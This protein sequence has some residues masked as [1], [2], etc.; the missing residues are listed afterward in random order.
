[1][2]RRTLR[3]LRK[4]NIEPLAFCDNNPLLWGEKVEGVRVFSLPEAAAKYGRD[5]VF[6]ITIWGGRATDTM[7]DRER[8]LRGV[9]CER[10]THFGLLYWKH[11]DAFFP[12][13]AANAAHHLLEQRDDVST[14]A[15][16]WSDDFSRREY[17]AQLRW[18]LHF[19]FDGLAAPVPG[20][21]Y[22]RDEFRP[23]SDRERFVDCGAFDGDTVESFIHHSNG[24]F[25]QVFAFEP[26]PLNFAKLA[27]SVSQTDYR[28]RIKIES[29][30]VG[31]TVCEVPFTGGGSEASA[32]GTGDLH[33]RCIAL[34]EYLAEEEPTFIKMDIEGFELEALAGARK[35]I[36]EQTPT[37]A[38]CSYHAQ[39]HLW[40]IPLQIR[41]YNPSYDFYIRPHLHHVWDLV[42]YAIP[43]TRL[44]S[45]QQVRPP[46]ITKVAPVI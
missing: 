25:E 24:E 19:D 3:G 29:A 36:E 20:P 31:S 43:K 46:S 17:M 15:A 11:G 39:D 22:F 35:I 12:H 40:K 7:A 27:E 8:Q 10:I 41:S 16:L 30:A 37:L 4:L 5:A 9:G 33:V 42:C 38:I 2:G 34:D 14:C 1:M 6:V 32:A 21:I 18:R 13:Y 23:L 45:Y 44:S 26:D 28:D